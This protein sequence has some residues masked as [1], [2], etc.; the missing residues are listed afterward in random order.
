MGEVEGF[1]CAAFC[2]D[3]FL[4]FAAGE[5]PVVSSLR[6]PAAP[7]SFATSSHELQA[8]FTVFLSFSLSFQTFQNAVSRFVLPFLALPICFSHNFYTFFVRFPFTYFNVCLPLKAPAG[9]AA[10]SIKTV[11]SFRPKTGIL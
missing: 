3:I 6:P 2:S 4:M 5:L 8:T 10:E 1:A 7:A 11:G 9:A